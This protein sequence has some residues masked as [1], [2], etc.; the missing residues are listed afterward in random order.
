MTEAGVE[1]YGARRLGAAEKVLERALGGEHTP[2]EWM[3]RTVSKNARTVLD[4]ACAS[5]GLT[6]RLAQ[7]GRVVVGL[8]PSASNLEQA[9]AHR[10]G[11][12]V[13]ADVNHLPF[14]DG[15]FDTVVTCLGM[16]MTV[17]RRRLL[18]EVSRVLRPG[19]VFAALLPSL[20][21]LN[22]SDLTLVSRLA[23]YLRVAPQLAGSA[24]FQASK[25][26]AAAGLTKTE[27]ARGR[28]FF[29]VRDVED[30]KVL[31]SGLRHAPDR[32]RVRNTVDFL[33]ERAKI[34]AVQ[35][36]LPMR[37]IVAIK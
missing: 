7:D 32:E 21:P 5:G 19:G 33:A 18:G 12:W 4:L 35:V 31:I 26:L 2:Y 29:N 15:S 8:D 17:N 10:G 34:K 1:W 22:R 9:R 36:P 3:A 23:G 25:S 11:P 27:D 6:R 16:G 24:E 30:A 37:R 20:R 28:F 14:D 13:Q